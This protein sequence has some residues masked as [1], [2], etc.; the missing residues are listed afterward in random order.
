[1]GDTAISIQMPG[2]EATTLSTMI[3]QHKG[4]PKEAE[5]REFVGIWV[6]LAKRVGITQNVINLLLE[7]FPIAQAEPIYRYVIE[8]DDHEVYKKLPTL[9]RTSGQGNAIIAKFY[10]SLLAFELVLPSSGSSLD[11]VVKD[12][13]AVALDKA[14]NPQSTIKKN[15]A[16]LLVRPLSKAG[17]SDSARIDRLR[18]SSLKNNLFPGLKQVME[19][20]GAKP[21]DVR[22]VKELFMWL[23][24]QMN[25]TAVSENDDQP[26]EAL[27][28]AEAPIEQTGDV[29]NPQAPA[30]ADVM[31]NTEPS[32][33]EDDTQIV[34]DQSVAD[35]S[36]V[37][38]TPPEQAQ[39][40][41]TI[42]TPKRT[43]KSSRPKKTKN[44]A[45]DINIDSV[46]GFLTALKKEHA[47]LEKQ[48][49][50][51]QSER[52]E[53]VRRVAELEQSMQ[54]AQRSIADLKTQRSTFSANYSTLQR[55][56]EA[57]MTENES[58]RAEL[59]EANEMISVID[60]GSTHDVEA[61]LS[62]L[63]RELSYDYRKYLMAA[64]QPMNEELGSIVLEQLR[65][66][67]EILMKHGV[68]LQ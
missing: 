36:E 17:I 34:G 5:R 24:K 2:D 10:L 3:A 31:T 30:V 15:V 42:D 49:T 48:I 53:H 62:G 28:T 44:D 43:S 46:I 18:A 63:G 13:N 67:F 65:T 39:P 68:E 16:A 52:A 33:V 26:D 11:I 59:E 27:P 7:G 41:E 56:F 9:V 4:N 22:A 66:V 8:T 50:R 58:L 12:L 29:D 14:Q 25:P 1:M 20:N 23:D 54:E 35:T 38:M 45:D 55:Q 51:L 32:S 6:S 47:D 60:E 64:N 57:L 37:T 21:E 61:A 19:R 40:E